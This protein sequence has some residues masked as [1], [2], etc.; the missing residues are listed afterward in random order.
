LKMRRPSL[1]TLTVKL[2]ALLALFAINAA[3]AG[4]FDVARLMQLLNTTPEGEVAYTEKK[5]SSL[6]NEPVVSSGTLAFH[7]P[8]TVEK[9]TLLPR[10]ESFRIAGEE[11]IVARKG[12]EKRFPLSSQ[13]L[14]SAFAA[15]L[16]GVLSGD[17]ELLRRHYQLALTG[18]EQQWQLVMTPMEAGIIRYI[19]QISVNGH[20]G[21]V[22]QIE[23]R[24]RSGDHS[25]LQ[26]K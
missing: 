14:L 1:Q 6:L 11:L 16:R 18:D 5:Y 3:H 12:A 22:E 4:D 13:P 24:E 2:L 10:K 17:A 21:H 15:S 26:V 19:E 25:V 23:V 7:R 9:N 20:A 8:D